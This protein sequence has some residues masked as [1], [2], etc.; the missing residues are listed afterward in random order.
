[1]LVFPPTN[2]LAN[3]SFHCITC[4]H[5][6]NHSSS[7]ATRPQNFSGFRTDSRYIRS[8]CAM[9]FMCA[10]ALNALGGRKT[11]FSFS[12][13]SILVAVSASTLAIEIILPR[14]ATPSLLH[15]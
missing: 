7:S 4:L 14:L 8:Y 3:G 1:M 10:F 6:L 15:K 11:R 13:D 12:V 9:L 2:H 5:F